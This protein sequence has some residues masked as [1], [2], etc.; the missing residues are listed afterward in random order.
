[1]SSIQ[2]LADAL[3]KGP[4]GI[5]INVTEKDC[6]VSTRYRPYITRRAP[7]ILEALQTVVDDAS[8]IKWPVKVAIAIHKIKRRS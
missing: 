2:E 8:H 1:M 5:Q 7:T 6:T 3:G 4:G